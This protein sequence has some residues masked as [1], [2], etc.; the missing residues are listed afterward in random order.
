MKRALIFLYI[1]I[2]L[3]AATGS[4]IS[5]SVH[6]K[7]SEEEEL[8][9]KEEGDDPLRTVYTGRLM[10]WQANNQDMPSV[11]YNPRANYFPSVGASISG[12]LGG[13]VENVNYTDIT[14]NEM[15][16]YMSNATIFML[17]SDGT[18]GEVVLG[19][20]TSTR[21]TVNNLTSSLSLMQCGLIMTCYSA[22]ST[23]SYNMSFI[24]KMV[25][26][27]ATCAIGFTT[28]VYVSDCNLF[29]E[30]FASAA[31]LPGYSVSYSIS[32]MSTSGMNQNMVNLCV[33]AGNGSTCLN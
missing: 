11:Q 33:C 31:T 14:V 19:P 13:T 26:K 7:E 23:N 17:H 1:C 27:G 25:N 8:T 10:A 12:N 15:R 6:A 4:S 9:E 24:Q 28:T 5:F 16:S 20:T 2:L 3:I 32:M 30:R 22:N 29:A 21:F 18:S